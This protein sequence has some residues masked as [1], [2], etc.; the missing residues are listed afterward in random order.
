[1][2]FK[3]WEI[4]LNNKDGKTRRQAEED[5]HFHVKIRPLMN[6]HNSSIGG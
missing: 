5:C 1:M 6:C 2:E 3:G 4:K